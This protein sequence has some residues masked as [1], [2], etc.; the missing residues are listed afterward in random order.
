MAKKK[1]AA[2]PK[3]GGAPLWMVSFGDMMTLI[4][5]FFILLVSMAE[6]Q[7]KGLLAK[8]VGSFLVALKSFGL[9]G[10]MGETE[11]LQIF[12]NVRMKF[13]LPPE[14]DP[15]RREEHAL[16]SDVE[17]LRADIAKLLRP[18]QQL[19]QPAV[20]QFELDSAQ[21]TSEGR[22][23]LDLLAPTLRPGHGQLL[24]LEGH[25][26]D[27]GEA[28]RGDNHWLAFERARAVRDYFVREHGFRPGRVDARA[29]LDELSPT[30]V[31][32]RMVDARLVTPDSDP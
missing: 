13:N 16:A 31:G 27:A 32:T 3:S 1:A 30:G 19:H 23:Y 9:P 10:A 8:G 20:A 24:L 12:N 25:A 5:T 2:E 15:E 7:Q 17:L 18:H 26:V 22:A 28:F 14:E 21:L 6:E 4:L 29:W 11:K